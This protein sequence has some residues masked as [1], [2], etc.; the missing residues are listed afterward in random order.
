MARPSA[1]SLVVAVV[2]LVLVLVPAAPLQTAGTSKSSKKSQTA[3]ARLAR[4]KY[5]VEHVS[6]C[7]ACHS[8]ARWETD[9]LPIASKRGAGQLAFPDAMLP[10]KLVVP[11]ITPDPETGS[12]RWSD[13]QFARA[14]RQGIGHDGRTLFPVMPYYFFRNMSDEDLA[15]VI[16]YVRTLPPI[17]NPLPKRVLPKEIEAML[18]PLPPVRGPVPGPDMSNPVKR[19]EYLAMLGNCAGCHTPIDEKFQPLPG[20]DFAGGQPLV[21]PWGEVASANLTPDPSGISYYDEKQFL[22][23]MRTGHVGARPLKQIMLWRYFRG[24]TDDDLKAIFAYLRTLKPV[25]HR[26]DN[27]EPVAYCKICRS[28]HGAGTLNH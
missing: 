12:G 28:K 9:G 24:M 3:S 18:Q 14:L 2:F 11:N 10:F 27:T 22:R 8:E 25:R 19:G 17:R 1:R 26:V 16:A 5:I 4:G 13:E 7:F 6:H 15:S 20:M 23:T 21:G